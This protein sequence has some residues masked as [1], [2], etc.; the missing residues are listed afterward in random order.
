MLTMPVPWG[1]AVWRV[2]LIIDDQRGTA[3][4]NTGKGGEVKRGQVYTFDNWPGPKVF[5]KNPN[6]SETV[7]FCQMCRPDPAFSFL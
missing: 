3:R 6:G 1:Y 2:A 4:E 7:S 5:L